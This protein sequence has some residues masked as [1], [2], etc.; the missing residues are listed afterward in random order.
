MSQKV[1]VYGTLRKGHGNHHVM[2]MSKGV[3]KGKGFTEN[4]FM[5]DMTFVPKVYK[6]GWPNHST[7]HIEGELYD[8]ETMRYM[9]LLEGHPNL[10]RREVTP[11]K[12]EN[13]SVDN[14]WLYFY[15]PRIK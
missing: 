12:L 10:Y 9:D 15:N 1:F 3:F 4:K 8:V 6:Y 11:I 2:E 7:K 14:A 13:G 5:S